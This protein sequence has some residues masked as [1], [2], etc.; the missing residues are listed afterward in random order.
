MTIMMM[1][2]QFEINN[3]IIII[4]LHQQMENNY[5]NMPLCMPLIIII[6]IKMIVILNQSKSIIHDD[7]FNLF[8]HLYKKKKRIRQF[9]HKS[10]I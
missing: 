8:I 2:F 3:K 6:I 1:T 10:S 7:P 5:N 4:I 9:Y